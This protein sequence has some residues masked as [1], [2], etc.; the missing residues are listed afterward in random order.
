MPLLRSRLSLVGRFT[1]IAES[2]LVDDIEYNLRIDI[3]TGRTG[4]RLSI[5]IVR[6]LLEIGDGVDGV[7][8]EHDGVASSVE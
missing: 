6:G 3:T 4:T 2:F 8:V 5:G 1:R 7:A